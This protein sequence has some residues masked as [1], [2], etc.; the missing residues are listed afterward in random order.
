M[1]RSIQSEVHSLRAK[2]RRW[3]I[4]TISV[5]ALLALILI[6]LPLSNFAKKSAPLQGGYL[7]PV[8][9]VPSSLIESDGWVDPHVLE[10]QM[11]LTL[12]RTYGITNPKASTPV[13]QW[14]NVSV[15]GTEFTEWGGDLETDYIPIPD[16]ILSSLPASAGLSP[17]RH[18]ALK[19]RYRMMR[20]PGVPQPQRLFITFQLKQAVEPSSFIEVKDVEVLA[21]IAAPFV[22]AL[23]VEAPS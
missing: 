21:R 11:L 1:E 10:R 23:H 16:Q 20:Y 8:Y 7:A 2:L 9:P 22:E 19:V 3:K 5:A 12:Q 15:D 14:E 6:V 13:E 4:A 18:Y 17:D